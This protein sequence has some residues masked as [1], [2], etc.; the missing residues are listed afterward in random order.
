MWRASRSSDNKA[1]ILKTPTNLYATEVEADAIKSKLEYEYKLGIK[2][3][4]EHIIQYIDFHDSNNGVLVLEDFDGINLGEF[5]DANG[6]ELILFFDF[7]IQIAETLDIIHQKKL[8]HRDINPSNIL[9]NP[10]TRQIKIIDFSIASTLEVDKQY[11]IEVNNLVGTLKYISP[12]QTGRINRTIDYRSDFYSLG[13]TYY[14]M[15]CGKTPFETSDPLTLVHNHIA[16][17]PPNPRLHNP[18]I[19]KVL[20]SILMKL[21]EKHAD[22]RYQSS[23]GL[24]QDLKRCRTA[25]QQN[26]TIESFELAQTDIPNKLII[27]QKLYGREK[28]FE[29]LTKKFKECLSGGNKNVFIS[30]YSGVGKTALVNE[31]KAVV[32]KESGVFLSGKYSDLKKRTAYFGLIK[33]FEEL[34]DKILCQSEQELELIKTEIKATLQPNVK[35]ITQFIPKLESLL[36]EQAEV[37]ALAPLETKNRFNIVISQF[38][39]IFAKPKHPLVL[40][41]DDLQWA[42]EAS[43]DLLFY[44]STNPEIECFFL[45]GSYR[46]NAVDAYHPLRNILQKLKEH[47][48]TLA[49][50]SLTPLQTHYAHQLV[51][52]T[53]RTEQNEVLELANVV[54]QK[55]DGNPFFIKIFLQTLY[56]NGL[57]FLSPERRWQWILQKI[58]ILP[59]SSNVIELLQHKIKEIPDETMKVLQIAAALGTCF[60]LELIA[61]IRHTSLNDIYHKFEFALNHGM[62]ISERDHHLLFVHDKLNESIYELLCAN[63]K[64]QL[65]YKI[66]TVMLLDEHINQD[67]MN[68]FN[69]VDH[70]NLAS[71]LL[72]ESEKLKVAR[73]N[74][75]SAQKAKENAAFSSALHY[76]RKGV[77]NLTASD[78]QQHYKLCYS[79]HLELAEAEYLNS[80]FSESQ[81][82]IDILLGK[83]KSEIEQAEIYTLLIYQYTVQSKYAEGLDVGRK[84]LRLLHVDLAE[85]DSEMALNKEVEKITAMVDKHEIKQLLQFKKMTDPLK[86]AA[87]STLMNM[88]PTAYFHDP[89]LYALL[90]AKMVSIS[91]KYGHTKESPKAYVTYAN[92]LTSNFLR[93]NQGAEFCQLGLQL[94]DAE[95]DLIQRCRNRFIYTAFL[96]HWTQPLRHGNKVARDGYKAGLE[97]GDLQYSGYILGFGIGNFYHQGMPLKKLEQKIETNIDFLS[98]T[99]HLMPLNANKAF[100]QAMLNLTGKTLEPLS[101][102]TAIDKEQ[103]LVAE[104]DQQSIVASSYFFTIKAQILF[105]Y[106][107]FENALD[108]IEQAE[109]RLSYMRGT[110]SVAEF[111]FYSALILLALYDTEKP[112]TNRY[113]EKI[114]K[115]QEKLDLYTQHCAANFEHK[116]LLVKAEIYRVVQNQPFEAMKYYDAAI[117]SASENGFIQA[118]AI[119]N[120]LAARFW[121]AINKPE[122]AKIYLKKAHHA[123][124]KWNASAK[125]QILEKE[126]PYIIELPTTQTLLSSTIVTSSS[127][128][129]LGI[130]SQRLDFD[131]VIKSS[132]ALSEE[133]VLSKLLKKVMTI[134]LENAGAERGALLLPQKNN[135]FIEAQGEASTQEVKVL[136]SLAMQNRVPISLIHYVAR[137]QENI[138]LNDALNEGNFT[139][140]AYIIENKARS[141]ICLPLLNQGELKGILYLENNLTSGAFIQERVEVLNVLSSQL[142]ISIANAHFYAK[143]ETKV[144]E[145]TQELNQ[146]NESLVILNQEK[147]EFMGIAAHDLKS[148]LAGIK[149]LAE[150]IK[151]TK[152]INNDVLDYAELI[153]SSSEKMLVLVSNLLDVNAIESGNFNMSIQAVDLHHIVESLVH[154]YTRRGKAK[155]ICIEL[156]VEAAMR[157]IKADTNTVQQILENLISNAVKYSPHNTHITVF[158]RQQDNDLQCEIKDQGP[159]LSAEDQKKL[160][161][162]FERLTPQPTGDESSTGLGLF[163][164]KKLAEAMH[165]RVWCESELGQG[166][167]FSAA[168]PIAQQVDIDALETVSIDVATEIQTITETRELRIL[169]AEDMRIN[170]KAAL[171]TLK[172]LGYHADEATNGQ[173][174]VTLATQQF[175]DIILMDV[176]M[177][178]LD[179]LEASRR[180]L[181][182]YEKLA[183][184]P[185]IVALSAISEAELVGCFDAGMQAH[186]NKPFSQ[187]DL[188]NLLLKYTEIFAN[189]KMEAPI[190]E[191]QNQH[192]PAIS[193]SIRILL[194]EDVLFVRK[195]LTLMLK[196]LGYQVD[197]MKDFQT[198]LKHLQTKPYDILLIGISY[199]TDK[200]DLNSLMQELRQHYPTTH[201]HPYII[202]LAEISSA[203]DKQIYLNAGMDA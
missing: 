12:E 51:A 201:P 185:W 109:N 3:K 58:I 27:S 165:S 173:E 105:I 130:S 145:R 41:L 135:W 124:N 91:L 84:V 78:W 193:D 119:A 203:Q 18:K 200:D 137:T 149:G 156:R 87:M 106:E 37:Q 75:S 76:L 7:A 162:R 34:V 56:D 90:A 202:A 128:S 30:G 155:Q 115:D 19:P 174:A 191:E 14:Y 69:I 158:I 42:D 49:E 38:V 89:A 74:L 150:E 53:F 113:L 83:A 182:H 184:S 52:D 5:V 192:E 96:F 101:F 10:Q 195:V 167:S 114:Y 71:S 17:T 54:Q 199:K 189:Q 141:L 92:I 33:A 28:E 186:L 194:F 129:S 147:N 111:Y 47:L 176:N 70:F 35:I 110:S 170:R 134:V 169:L 120:E 99:K 151:L 36:G 93:F 142:S 102:D 57:V 46:E 116:Y 40:F 187:K 123:Y 61:K 72:N 65:H 79:L 112:Q 21:M 178:V 81:A 138:I 117:K 168:F 48:P 8:V 121:F 66:A 132:L 131:S 31:F 152:G 148:P 164:V 59:S 67:E 140:D 6:L 163:N 190:S 25:L 95:H 175:Y 20:A 43:L 80:H 104:W 98:K 39:R 63:D 139:N 177:P 24:I 157:H 85:N 154:E 50:L 15:L 32:S 108:A 94:G 2:F 127:T 22:N 125:V 126:Y 77:K 26:Q 73:L 16:I 180:I 107:D 133:I 179:G 183:K 103:N 100:K 143:L 161:G 60:S 45:I 166:A 144:E 9:F 82:V 1:V 64:A 160:F 198:M 188:E 153:H 122:F 11:D 181:A 118:E 172:K 136:E 88:Q 146:K 44:L 4:H 68:T 97:C 159:G 29:F 86:Q 62:L 197:I 196:K 171:L 13:V 23:Y 55:T